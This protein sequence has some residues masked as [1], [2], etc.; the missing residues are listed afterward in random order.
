M[1]KNNLIFSMKNKKSFTLIELL[2][3]IAIIAILASMLL[4]ALQ[5]A[6]ARANQAKCMSNLKELGRASGM[7][8]DDYDDWFPHPNADSTNYL[9]HDA[10]MVKYYG[11]AKND[12]SILLC[13]TGD[14]YGLGRKSSS[15]ENYSY[16]F[17][18]YLVCLGKNSST[19]DTVKR[20]QV[21]NPS[22]RFLMSETGK[23]GWRNNH[24]L[25]YAIFNDRTYISFRHSKRTGVSFVDQHVDFLTV[26][27]FPTS[28]ANTNNFWKN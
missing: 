17:N 26:D 8:A 20:G 9:F 12:P 28:T 3:V 21:I 1:Q 13:P 15:N 6:R 10:T 24:D 5:Q 11:E 16:I 23:D 19:T 25:G 2:V 27:N 4:P 18:N 22:G 7:Y 14:R